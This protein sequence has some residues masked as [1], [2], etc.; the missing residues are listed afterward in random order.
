[1]SESGRCVRCLYPMRD[2]ICELASPSPTVP[3]QLSEFER[4]RL[5]RP[6]LPSDAVSVE[7]CLRHA[8]QYVRE[9]REMDGVP[10]TGVLVIV[11]G[12]NGAKHRQAM[13]Q[14]GVDNGI[15]LMAYEVDRAHM[16]RMM[17]VLA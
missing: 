4:R 9:T 5:A 3:E 16:L 17:G 11:I 10:I 12:N 14:A 1:M 15:K 6:G 8:L 13:Y 7:D 2:C